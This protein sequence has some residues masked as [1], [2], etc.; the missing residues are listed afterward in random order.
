MTR[1]ISFAKLALLSAFLALP[2]GCKANLQRDYVEAMERTRKAIE[3]DVQH[4][5]YKPDARS[6]KTLADWKDAN[7]EAFK[8]LIE[9]EKE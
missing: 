6:A 8:V 9:Q 2:I 5:L 3:I 4:G 1:R 7:E